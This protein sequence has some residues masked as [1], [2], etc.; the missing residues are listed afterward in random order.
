MFLLVDSTRGWI[1]TWLWILNANL[2]RGLR[3]EICRRVKSRNF[4]MMIIIRVHPEVMRRF[5]R[6][7]LSYHLENADVVFLFFGSFKLWG[8]FFLVFLRLMTDAWSLKL[9]SFNRFT[10]NLVAFSLN[11]QLLIAHLWASSSPVVCDS[12][13]ISLL[14]LFWEQLLVTVIIAAASGV[15]HVPSRW[16][17]WVCRR[18]A[19]TI[20]GCHGLLKQ[21]DWFIT[22][23]LVVPCDDDWSL[24]VTMQLCVVLVADS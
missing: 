16:S 1:Q 21:A 14:V 11:V 15:S 2:K 7:L 22:V 9:L 13:I 20:H 3:Q 23:L 17:D 6:F 12:R 5:F 18:W 4:V 10:C 8:C 19:V 24:R